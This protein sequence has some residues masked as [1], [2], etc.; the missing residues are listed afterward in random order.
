VT[1][2]VKDLTPR[3]AQITELLLE[4]LDT[5]S[6]ADRLGLSYH[7]VIDHFKTLFEAFG[8]HSRVELL[9]RMRQ[10]LRQ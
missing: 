1:R 9:A 7:T 4:G 6:I 2:G 10:R 5:Q 8:V 3:Q